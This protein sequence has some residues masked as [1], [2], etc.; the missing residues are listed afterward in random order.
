[1]F[2]K[3]WNRHHYPR[4][5]CPSETSSRSCLRQVVT[6]FVLI[7]AVK[8]RSKC[9]EKTSYTYETF[10]KVCSLLTAV[11]NHTRPSAEKRLDKT[12]W[13]TSIIS[14]SLPI[15]LKKEYSLKPC[16]DPLIKIII[17]LSLCTARSQNTLALNIP[18]KKMKTFF[19]FF[20]GHSYAWMPP[21]LTKLHAS[22][23]IISASI[24]LGA[25]GWT[26]LNLQNL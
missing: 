25:T 7:I 17:L 23:E 11:I 1:M 19:G 2:L 22:E 13:W 9:S 5:L 18:W 12:F 20:N 8:R 26:M 16:S 21:R 24:F 3:F 10:S 4:F 14:A 15:C 6:I